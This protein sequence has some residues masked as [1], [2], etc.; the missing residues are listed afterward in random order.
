MCVFVW[1]WA[2]VY[3]Y[4]CWLVFPPIANLYVREIWSRH[5]CMWLLHAMCRSC[6]PKCDTR[7]LTWKAVPVIGDHIQQTCMLGTYVCSQLPECGLSVQW[8]VKIFPWKLQYRPIF[9]KLQNNLPWQFPAIRYVVSNAYMHGFWSRVC[10]SI[11]DVQNCEV[12][13]DVVWRVYTY[14]YE[15]SR[16]VLRQ[17]T[18]L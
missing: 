11:T 2:L 16:P 5:L 1:W 12:K 8:N 3:T 10:M 4:Q 17:V 13:A 18:L 9:R 6:L 15:A 14:T 7:C